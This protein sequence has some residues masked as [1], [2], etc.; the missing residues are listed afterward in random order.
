[1]HPRR[2]RKAFLC[3]ASA[4]WA[5]NYWPLRDNTN[6]P[7]STEL[8]Q[9]II[10][11]SIW[12]L[13]LPRNVRGRE[14]DRVSWSSGSNSDF[15]KDGAGRT[16]SGPKSQW[17]DAKECTE[18]FRDAK[19]RRENLV[20]DGNGDGTQRRKRRRKKLDKDRKRKRVV[21]PYTNC[22]QRKKRFFVCLPSSLF[23]P[24]E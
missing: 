15:K 24:A 11:R 18:V 22:L 4:N 6:L 8:F 7:F 1:M 9:T 5:E 23:S 21:R 20:G 13:D 12:I 16:A 19:I 14:V 10:R 2:S 17:R 3:P